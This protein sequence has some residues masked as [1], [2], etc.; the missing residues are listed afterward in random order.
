MAVSL[1]LWSTPWDKRLLLTWNTNSSTHL[2][3]LWKWLKRQ[4]LLSLQVELCLLWVLS[5]IENHHDFHVTF[6]FRFPM[7]LTNY[8]LTF[9]RTRLQAFLA[10]I[11]SRNRTFRLW[12]LGEGLAAETWNLRLRNSQ[13]LLWYL[14]KFY[15]AENVVDKEIRLP[16]SVKSCSTFPTLSQQAWLYSSRHTSSWTQQR[17]SGRKA[18]R[19]KDW[20]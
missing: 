11:S 17:P 2:L 3:T 1:S 4:D 16:S 13:I 15:S 8:F 6:T 14:Y 20:A 10:D 12:W 19:W 5:T 7:W 9:R 18:E